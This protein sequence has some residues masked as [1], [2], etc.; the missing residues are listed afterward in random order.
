MSAAPCRTSR[1]LA[2]RSAEPAKAGAPGWAARTRPAARRALWIA[3]QLVPGAL[4]VYLAF[5]GGG[6]F[7]TAPA[8]VAVGLAI[9]LVLRV[10]TSA[11]PFAGVGPLVAIIA[12]ALALLAI[13]TLAS[14]T[15]SNAPGRALIE[16][17]RVLLYLLAFVVFA[18]APGGRERLAWTVGGV[19][20][21]IVIVCVSGFVT[22]TL[23]E[24]WTVAPNIANRRLS[25]PLT[26]WN[27]LGLLA[28]LGTLLALH[29]TASE[30]EPRPVR[31]LAAGA[32]PVLACTLLLTFSR[33][34]IAAGAIG[35]A[36]YLLLARPRGL[37]S[38][39]IAV[40]PTSVVALRSTYGADALATRDPTGPLAVAQG[41]DVA[42][43]VVLCVVAAVVL[44]VPGLWLDARLARL[45]LPPGARRPVGWAVA[46]TVVGALVVGSLAL[47]APDRLQRQYDNFVQGNSIDPTAARERLVQVGNNGRLQHWR[48]ALDAYRAD[49]VT[50]AGAGTYQV[51]WAQHREDR[52]TVN[53]AHSLYLEVL[54]ELGVVGLGLVLIVVLGIL[55]GLAFKLRG[56]ERAIHAAVFSAAL[57]WA[58]H[59]GVDWDWELPAVTLWVFALAGAALGARPDLASSP[60]G[61]GRTARLAAALGCLV[62]AVTPALV[63]RSQLRLDD[64]VRALRAGDCP[65]SVDAAL[66]SISAV[67][68]R[69]EP[70]EVLAYCDVRQGQE[71]L[72]V[73]VM[74]QAV[75]RDPENWEFHYGLA[76]VRGAARMDPRPAARRAVELNPLS[77]LARDAVDRFDTRSPA[78]WE[79]R[80]RG[81]R[82]AF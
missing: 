22:R 63:A 19:L 17:D 76:L 37:L 2:T 18:S 39:V 62:L 16:F 40:V 4:I 12:A 38:A 46:L 73:R 43:T 71:P 28:A 6:F 67:G 72:A 25:Y 48:V 66:D 75:E 80:A 33:G 54:A 45:R 44:R 60:R 55:G 9:V 11:R 82:L 64:S 52:I 31:V 74:Q 32:V 21:G 61:P 69:A 56:P 70:Y 14:A 36:A 81:A 10:T 24:V 26:Y 8:V 50:G 59:A 47:D 1:S 79:R 77:E 68:A 57:A 5:E 58:V 29:L 34:A 49:P 51:L 78:K 42:V 23:P 27:A 35:L 15:W 13:W 41:H 7:P 65:A 30:R 3:A 20:A 53:D